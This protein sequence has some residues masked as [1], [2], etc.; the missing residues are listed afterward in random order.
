MEKAPPHEGVWV[1]LRASPRHGV[2][3]FAIRAIPAG[4]NLFASDRA[5]IRWIDIA[6]IADIDTAAQQL[7]WD[8]GIQRDGQIGVPS[9]FNHL[10]V[11][12]YLNEP[13]QG[14]E[15]N[16]MASDTYEMVT[17][18]DIAEGE[19]LTVRYATF[20]RPETGPPPGR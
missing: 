14:T 5:A 11:G 7:Y 8:F 15:A 1:R 19:E 2:G 6:A 18:R 3:V 10:T 13:A 4:T 20:S 12:W 17:C 9:D 16:V